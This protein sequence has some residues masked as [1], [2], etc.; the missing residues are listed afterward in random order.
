[1]LRRM[2]LARTD[3]SEDS[4]ASII[5]ATKIGELGTA[6]ELTS[7]R[8]TLRRNTST[9][10]LVTLMMEE[11]RIS[12]ASAL[13]GVTWRKIPEEVILQSPTQE[14]QILLELFF[15]FHND[16]FRDK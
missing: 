9:P 4:I 13:T 12:D 14:P 11:I 7:N 6:L 8:S 1:M 5:R 16:R 15:R 10:I 3:N 2:A